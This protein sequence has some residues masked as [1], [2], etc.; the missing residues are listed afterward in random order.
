MQNPNQMGYAAYMQ[1]DWRINDRLTLNLGLRWE[2]EPG[3]TDFDNRLS[4]RLDLSSPIPEMQATPPP[5]PAQA[6]QLMASKGYSYTYN[7]AWVFAGDDSRGAWA[8]TWKNFMPRVGAN[9][10]FGD[11]SVL[12]FAYARY[13]MP[14]NAVRDTLGDFVTQYSGYAQTTNTLGLSVGTPQQR[15]SDPYPAG[16]NP[17]IEPYGQAYG[18]YTN[19]GGAVSLDE[20]N[21]RP[22]LNDRFNLS[23]Q[24]QLWAGMIVDLNYFFNLGTRVPYSIDINMMDPAYRYE[25][26]TA[27][28]ANVTNPFRN[29][30]TP[31]TFPGPLRNAATVTLGSLLKPYPQYTSITQTNTNGKG[32]RTH[33]M[34]IRAQ[35]PFRGG[36]SFLAAYAWNHERIQQTFDDLATYRVLQTDG[37]EGWEWRPTDNPTHRFTA[38]ASYMIPVGRGQKFGSDMH[39][40]LDAAIGGWQYSATARFYSGRPLLFGTSYNVSG[41][42]KLDNP[43]RDKWFDTSMFSLL[44]D[45]NTPRT[46]PWYFDGLDGPGAFFCDMTLTKAFAISKYR[47]EARFEA[48]NA[49]NQIVWDN[50]DLT[51]ANNTNFGKVTRK[52][53]DSLGR[54]IQFGLRFVF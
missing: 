8:S 54:E 3:P 7:G 30:L 18:R 15:L 36:L 1:D 41:N 53:L 14:S 37:E 4:Q 25:L 13:L 47:L 21:L 27:L 34:E 33:T 42:P 51:L 52:R 45:T 26:K 40:A 35:R 32:M 2:F 16:L 43:T 28:N 31:S 29:Y 23:F 22:Q 5:M 19:L 49:L 20:Y 48:Y 50:P 9:Y 12:R 17:V 44:A 46:N 38:A 24:K 6:V 10:R 11:D 39:P